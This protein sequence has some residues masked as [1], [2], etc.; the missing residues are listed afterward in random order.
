MQILILILLISVKISISVTF[1]SSSCFTF[2][3][4]S[5]HSPFT[6]KKLFLYVLISAS[7]FSNSLRR[8][9]ISM[10][11]IPYPNSLILPFLLFALHFASKSR[12]FE[13]LLRKIVLILLYIVSLGLWEKQFHF[14]A[15]LF[16]LLDLIAYNRLGKI[17]ELIIFTFHYAMK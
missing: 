7:F 11:Q 16:A 15:Q 5:L 9:A 2:S 1:V 12:D 6:D 17:S 10:V 8:K 13:S 14:E 3:A 4:A